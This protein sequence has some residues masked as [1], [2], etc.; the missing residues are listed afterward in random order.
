MTTEKYDAIVLGAGQSGG[1]LAVALAGAGWR[2]ALVERKHVG[3]SCINFG[4]T[5]TKALLA[6]AHVAHTARHAA[7]YGV[8]TGPVQV[9]FE[10]VQ[11][12]R[13]SIVTS[14]RDPLRDSYENTD[15]LDLLRGEGMFSPSGGPKTILVRHHDGREQMYAAEHVFINTGTRAA[16]P[17]VEGIEAVRTLDET[18]IMA[19]EELPAHLVILGGGPV[20]VEFAQ[21]FRRF[22]SKVTIIEAQAQLL[23][24]ED[25]DIAGAMADVLE[26]EG[27]RLVLNARLEAVAGA[28]DGLSLQVRLSDGRSQQLAGSHLLRAVGRTPNT[29]ALKP[30]HA[31]IETDD[32]GYICVDEHLQTNVPGIYALGDV[33]GG[34][35]FTHISY[36]DYRVL[37]ANLLHGGRASIAGR[38]VPYT[39]FTDPQLGRVGL[40]EQQAQEQGRRYKVA[41]M[42]MARVA[43]ARETG[44][45]QGLMKVI[46]D[47]ENDQILGCAMLGAQGGEMMAVLQTA[48]MGGLPYTAIRDG[49][50]AHPTYA[51]SLNN[52]LSAV[53]DG[54]DDTN[55]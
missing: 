55:T 16:M 52:L 46:L 35:A 31:G 43:R 20:G 15:N 1:P 36:D 5:P 12:R 48:M 47:A 44:E 26:A 54:A 32:K 19:L 40:T 7:Q 2:T 49:V 9:N 51:E 10:A 53:E 21:M 4:C 22:G 24:G 8:Q 28:D 17:P 23:S 38:L 45:T 6:S 37:C 50:F 33:K 30:E 13:Q 39:L 3:G 18:G 14:F 11:Q 34:P 27:I 41:R 29:D 25:A 42:P